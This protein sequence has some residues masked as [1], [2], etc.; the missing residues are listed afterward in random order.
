[1]TDQGRPPPAAD[2]GVRLIVLYK[3]VKAVVQAIVAVVLGLALR[4]GFADKLAGEATMFAEHS[5][6]PALVR[7]AQW[8]S[9]E[10]TPQHLEVI[11]LLLFADAVV[12]AIEG[13]VLIRGYSWGRWL[14]VVAT[15]GLLP[16]ELF[17]IIRRPLPTRIILFLVNALIVLYLVMGAR[18]REPAAAAQTTSSPGR[19]G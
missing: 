2:T 10:I 18:R 3:L 7:L 15:G 1:M 9:R 12:S 17:E 19:A 14:V 5:V 16:L 13:W 4:V 11:A 8:F 6:H